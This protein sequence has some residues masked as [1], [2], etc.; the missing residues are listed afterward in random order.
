M[1][2]KFLEKKDDALDISKAL[3]VSIPEIFQVLSF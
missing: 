3:F 2:S 1:S